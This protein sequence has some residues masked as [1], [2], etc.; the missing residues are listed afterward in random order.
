[1]SPVNA[2]VDVVAIVNEASTV[3]R[4]VPPTGGRRVSATERP[5]GDHIERIAAATIAAVAS[6]KIRP[7]PARWAARR[8][9]GR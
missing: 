2:A 8:G 1:M 5:H 4:V 3:A 6:T 7:G 9:A